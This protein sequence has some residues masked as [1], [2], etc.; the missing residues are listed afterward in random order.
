MVIEITR[1]SFLFSLFVYKRAFS[2]SAVKCN[3]DRENELGRRNRDCSAILEIHSY[4]SRP[5]LI[6]YL[7]SLFIHAFPHFTLPYFPLNFKRCTNLET[8]CT[9]T[10]GDTKEFL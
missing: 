8:K 7:S 4:H 2:I 10:A 6:K 5:P 1:S 9:N 3:Q